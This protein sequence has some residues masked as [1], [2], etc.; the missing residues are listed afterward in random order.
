LYLITSTVLY[1]TMSHYIPQTP[2]PS[3]AVW[4]Q[5]N[6]TPCNLTPFQSRQWQPSSST[7]QG[8]RLLSRKDTK[9]VLPSAG[10]LTAARHLDAPTSPL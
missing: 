2:I 5:L 9:S 1:C 4:T 6:A 7:Q 10:V 8:H 3:R